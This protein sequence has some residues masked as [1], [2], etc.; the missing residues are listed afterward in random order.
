MSRP[1]RAVL[2]T[3]EELAAELDSDVTPVVLDVR[4]R[5]DRPDGWDDYI[6][7]HIRRAVYV[8]LDSELADP[9]QPPT[10]GRHPLPSVEDLE[11]AARGWGVGSRS[12]VVVYDEGSG[13]AAARAW[14]LLR[15]AGFE[16][17]RVLDGGL[18]TWIDERRPLD[19]GVFIPERGDV[20][21]RYGALP[22]VDIDGAAGFP[23]HGV[24]LDARSGERYRGEVEPIDPV[25]GHIP[26]AVSA[27]T[28]ENVGPGGRFRSDEE[29]RARFQQLGVVDEVAV[30]CGSGVTAAHEALALTI[31][32]FEPALFPGSWSAWSNHAD[33]PVALGSEPDGSRGD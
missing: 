11:N 25:A 18:Q 32:G 21:L 4:W 14:W 10:A 7:G 24:L 3:A 9:W 33:R 26:G 29:L 1:R 5:L 13:L 28:T 23:A 22:I 19:Q 27:P 16:D 8:R 2:V 20:V 15:F 30:Y 31:A 6:A 17:V 12:R